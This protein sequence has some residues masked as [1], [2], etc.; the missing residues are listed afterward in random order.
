[1]RCWREPVGHNAKNADKRT[2]GGFRKQGHLRQN[3]TGVDTSSKHSF[4]NKKNFNE[5][6]IEVKLRLSQ[7]QSTSL[8]LGEKIALKAIVFFYRT[9]SR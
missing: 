4:F 7:W 6:K 8:K 5:F 2:Y 3:D 1:M 9:T